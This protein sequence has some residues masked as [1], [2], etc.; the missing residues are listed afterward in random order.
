MNIGGK[1]KSNFIE[2]I[3]LIIF[4]VSIVSEVAITFSYGLLSNMD[5]SRF[6]SKINISVI[7]NK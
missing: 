2:K 6:Q 5:T 1:M 7:D 3:I 4:F